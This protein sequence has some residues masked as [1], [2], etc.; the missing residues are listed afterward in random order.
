MTEKEQKQ[1]REAAVVKGVRDSYYG[2]N[3]HLEGFLSVST[4]GKKQRSVFTSFFFVL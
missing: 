1:K 3:A 4:E 2:G